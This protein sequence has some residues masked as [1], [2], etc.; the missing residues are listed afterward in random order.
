VDVNS[1]SSS[2]YYKIIFEVKNLVEKLGVTLNF[3][4]HTVTW[5]TDENP[6]NNGDIALYHQ[7]SRL[8]RII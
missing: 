4:D 6:I 1:E 5:N 2:T 8:L 3:N 7:Q